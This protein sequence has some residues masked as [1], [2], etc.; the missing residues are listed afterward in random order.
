MALRSIDNIAERPYK[1][2]KSVKARGDKIRIIGIDPGLNGTGLAWNTP[3]GKPVVE[4]VIP[5]QRSIRDKAR[6][7]IHVVPAICFDVLV[8]EVPQ[9]YQGAKQKG[10]PNDLVRLA[11][12]AGNVEALI[13][14]YNVIEVLPCT[15][16]G[17]L[18]KKVHHE[19]IRE[20]TGFLRKV[21]H[22]ALDA[23]GILLY[24]EDVIAAKL[25]AKRA[26]SKL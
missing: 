25:A 26:R 24:G 14:T 12:L 7:I 19:R 23:L 15:W 10:D 8:I 18:S 13:S 20:R 2:P 9:I 4:H 1:S 6:E 21:P 16:K 17:Q 22:D 5:K 3:S 11:L